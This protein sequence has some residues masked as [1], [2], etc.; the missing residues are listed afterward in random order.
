MRRS[1]RSI[2]GVVGATTWAPRGNI[3]QEDVARFPRARLFLFNDIIFSRTKIVYTFLKNQ[4]G[5]RR[6]ESLSVFN[7][8]VS[9]IRTFICTKSALSP[10]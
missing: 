4:F 1:E 9:V 6:V 2:D 7:S 8:W 5:G 10:A 3:W